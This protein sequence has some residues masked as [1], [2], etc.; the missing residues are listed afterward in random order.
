MQLEHEL[1]E[2]RAKNKRTEIDQ[3]EF[4]C[5]LPEEE[6]MA[7]I[8]ELAAIYKLKAQ[9]KE[10]KEAVQQRLTISYDDFDIVYRKGPGGE[11][12]DL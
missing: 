12:N 3:M 8:D 11:E 10:A 1:F 2:L 5:R 6:M 4:C 9:I 7:C